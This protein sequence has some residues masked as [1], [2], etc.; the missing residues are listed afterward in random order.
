[1]EEEGQ[2]PSTTSPT[3]R[4]TFPQTLIGL[5]LVMAVDAGEAEDM[6]KGLSGKVHQ[7]QWQ[8]REQPPGMTQG[9]L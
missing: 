5:R 8:S 2:N 7:R 3:M 4:V 9:L 1:M 6:A